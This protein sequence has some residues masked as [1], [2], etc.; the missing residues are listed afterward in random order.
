MDDAAPAHNDGSAESMEVALRD[1]LGLLAAS[2]LASGA[3]MSEAVRTVRDVVT[4]AAGVLTPAG[5]LA[6]GGDAKYLRLRPANDTFRRRTG[7]ADAAVA[8]LVA[9]GWRPD[10]PAGEWYALRL[11]ADSERLALAAALATEA[12]ESYT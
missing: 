7:G 8:F 6:P 12:A 4:R 2:C 5:T 9:A 11:P 10:D 1:A 3:S